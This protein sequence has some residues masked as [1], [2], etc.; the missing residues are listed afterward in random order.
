M[1]G[2]VPAIHA[3]RSR[4]D[5]KRTRV[6]STWMAGTS[7]TMTTTGRRR[8][9]LPSGWMLDHGQGYGISGDRSRGPALRAGVGP[10]PSLSRIHAAAVGGDDAKPGGALHELR[11]SLVPH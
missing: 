3:V 6:G 9:K 5:L 1:V 2:L 11:H 7:R 4:Q 10:H 8:S